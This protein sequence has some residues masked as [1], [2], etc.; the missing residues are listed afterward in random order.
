MNSPVTSG[1]LVINKGAVPARPH[2]YGT[3]LPRRMGQ[4][5]D[6]RLLLE[7]QVRLPEEV[8]KHRSYKQ[9]IWPKQGPIYSCILSV[10]T[11]H[12]D[13]HVFFFSY[14]LNV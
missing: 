1:F 11:V 6:G 7:H 2:D 13:F 9:K 14:W 8:Y 5:D 3:S 12:I 10:W 4:K